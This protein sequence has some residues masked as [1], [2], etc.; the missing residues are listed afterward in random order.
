MN[1]LENKWKSGEPIIVFTQNRSGHHNMEI[2]TRKHVIGQHE[3][4]HICVKNKQ[5][6]PSSFMNYHQVCNK[7][8]RSAPTRVLVLINL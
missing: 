5:S 7:H 1:P 3:P 8:L 6:H 2:K 4:R